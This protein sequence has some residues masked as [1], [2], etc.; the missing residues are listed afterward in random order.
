MK[1]KLFIKIYNGYGHTHNL[2]VYGHVFK[3][4][5]VEQKRFSTRVFTNMLYLLRLFFVKPVPGVHLSLQEQDQ[6]IDG[7]TES[8]GFFAFEWD[9]SHHIKAGWHP[10]EVSTTFNEKEKVTGS[11][12]VF[13]PHITQYGFISD[14]DDTIMV[15]H[16]STTWRRLAELFTKN[17]RTRNIFDNVALHYNLLAKAHTDANSPNPFFYV[18]SSEWNLYNYLSDF[19]THH[20]L[21]EGIFLLSQVKRW[22]QLLKTGKTKHEGKLLRILR[23]LEAFPSQKFVLLGDNSQSDPGIY[24]SLARHHPEKIVAIY[25]RNVNSYKEAGTR[26]LLT[27]LEEELNNTIH[28]CFFST[29]EEA[30]QHSR[31]I[32]LI[33]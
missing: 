7:K 8:D 9:S 28:T 26:K 22:Y 16:S 1:K 14:I 20:Q 24:A 18:S 6:Q 27:G 15:S 11:G 4:A 32:G 23:I 29:S 19:F 13:I 17:A 30:I 10:V 12:K 5:P 21:P 33:E 31:K 3:K 2:H 25:I